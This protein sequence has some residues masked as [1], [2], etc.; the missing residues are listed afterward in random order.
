MRPSPLR[1]P[2]AVLRQIIGLG[3]KQ[4]A[5][6]VG[7]STPTIQAI[8][9]GK[10]KLSET[11]AARIEEETG[12]SAGWLLNGDVDR[13][14]EHRS[15]AAYHKDDYELA[16]AMRSPLPKQVDKRPLR[17]SFAAGRYY[18]ESL[19]EIFAAAMCCD[20]PMAN[21]V[22][23]RVK[24]FIDE[25]TQK[26]G[27]APAEYLEY[28]GRV[29]VTITDDRGEVCEE[30]HPFARSAWALRYDTA[31]RSIRAHSP[32]AADW[33]AK[34]MPNPAKRRVKKS[35]QKSRKKAKRRSPP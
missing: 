7:K 32:E 1:H 29:K 3:Q 34:N 14:I 27:E 28:R 2:L 10:L 33:L 9:L 31:L 6:H 13:P 23:F 8:E 21:V 26:F 4:L 24:Q 16:R 25:M 22:D 35:S 5:E 19:A 12:V 30:L 15:G 20:P 11:L 18:G 17:Y